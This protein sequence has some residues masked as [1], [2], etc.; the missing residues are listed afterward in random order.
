MTKSNGAIW[1]NWEPIPRS[2]YRIEYNTN[3]FNAMAGTNRWLTNSVL[4]PISAPISVAVS[5]NPLTNKA[6][7]F[8]VK[9]L[10]RTPGN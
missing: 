10:G 7:F 9:S 2:T 5:P 4:T 3:N 1:L 6:A 8:R